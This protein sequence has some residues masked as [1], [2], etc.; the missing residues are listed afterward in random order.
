MPKAPRRCQGQQGN[1]GNLIRNSNYCPD[2]TREKAWSGKR[3]HSGHITGTAQWKRVR[4][5]ALDRDG[6][7][8]QIE[9]PACT[10]HATQVDHIVNVAA[11]G[12]LY[13]LNNLQS[14]CAPCNAR[15]AQQESVASRTATRRRARHPGS[16]EQSPGTL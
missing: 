15:K 12:A 13:D 5:E 4:L 10:G 16:Y 2:C 6:Y 1:C 3:T 14:A 11:G 7:Q 8:C 9:G